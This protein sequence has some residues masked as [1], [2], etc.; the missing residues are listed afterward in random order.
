MAILVVSDLPQLENE[1]VYQVLL[2]RGAE[3]DTAETFSVNAGGAHILVVQSPRPMAIFD[4]VGV[5]I[6][7][8][9]GSEQRTGDVVLVGEIVSG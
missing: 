6:E 4:Q 1:E 8:V 9:G 2:I 5:S 3:H 7:P